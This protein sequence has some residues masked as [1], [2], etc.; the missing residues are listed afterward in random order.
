[1]ANPSGILMVDDEPP[2]NRRAMARRAM[3]GREPTAKERAYL[4]ARLP[5][6]NENVYRLADTLTPFPALYDAYQDPSLANITRA[7]VQTAA[8]V[9]KPLV[10]LGALGLGYGIAAA[11]DAGILDMGAKAQTAAQSRAR[12][13]EATARAKAE[14][15]I[16]KAKT[17]A[18]RQAA[19][20]EARRAANA[21]AAEKAASD[22]AEYDRA[23]LKAE[24]LRDAELARD[25]R[26]SETAV[27]KVYDKTGGAAAFMAP[28]AVG[29]GQR[30]AQGPS[31][32]VVSKYV[33]PFVEGGAAAYGINSLPLYYD[34]YATEASNPTKQAY[35]VYGREL[36]AGHPRK[37]EAL[38]Y[39]GPES[40]GGL[41]DLNPVRAT[42]T[43]ELKEGFW[44]RLGMSAIE[45][46]MG[47]LGYAM[48]GLPS[49]MAG[50]VAD[51]VEG[52]A[53]L[54]GRAVKGYNR[55]MTDAVDAGGDLV[56]ARNRVAAMPPPA[57][58]PPQ[59]VETPPAAAPAP[60]SQGILNLPMPSAPAKP[61][62][63]PANWPPT[64]RPAK[65]GRFND[66][67]YAAGPGILVA[68]GAAADAQDDPN[69]LAMLV[70]AGIL[71]PSVLN[72]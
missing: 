19:E 4:R 47:P 1:M 39:A 41:P 49:R 37:A 33:A 64:K 27:G 11:K 8:T 66:D 16:L 61:A 29:L 38:R 14:E 56:A 57:P 6:Q 22:K 54:P 67:L 28:F 60:A 50:K 5:E 55:G 17:E 44:P 31:G 24:S 30:L 45:G 72:R 63:D 65:S 32:G 23:V 52:T 42:A 68:G 35:G 10:A 62:A 2:V 18:E 25:R 36:P 3:A 26:F 13:Q 69:M 71:P 70:R 9:G 7:G 53:T 12:A 59:L 40:E 51:T 46:T 58:R 34:A 15:G 43:R 48:G 21:L 20:N